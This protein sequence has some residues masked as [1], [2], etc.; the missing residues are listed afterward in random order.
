MQRITYNA[1]K[2]MKMN[3]RRGSESVYPRRREFKAT[4]EWWNGSNSS[5]IR[6]Q[7]I[8]D[9]KGRNMEIPCI[10][11]KFVNRKGKKVGVV[12]AMTAEE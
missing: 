9:C 6:W 8:P 3:H 2:A 5:D 11:G 4:S 10:E 1:H 7:G 12:E